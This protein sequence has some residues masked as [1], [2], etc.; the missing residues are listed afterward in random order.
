MNETL[1]NV[2]AFFVPVIC[3]LIV[4]GG[5]L[6][7]FLI[8]EQT[9]EIQQRTDKEA[10]AHFIKMAG[11]AVA[12]EVAYVTQAYADELKKTA[13]STRRHSSSHDARK[14]P[15][16]LFTLWALSASTNAFI[17]EFCTQPRQPFQRNTRLSCRCSISRNLVEAIH[18]YTIMRFYK[19]Y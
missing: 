17:C 3:A 1:A 14:E 5:A 4:G 16:G 7:A 12:Q 11:E 15:R 8:S 18:P 9:G 19:I 2:A 13:P 10:T 6:F